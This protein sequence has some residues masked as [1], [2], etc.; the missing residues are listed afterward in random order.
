MHKLIVHCVGF[1]AVKGTIV[2]T[3]NWKSFLE[4][5]CF[6]KWLFIFPEAPSSRAF[7]LTIGFWI[8]PFTILSLFL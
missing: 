7:M 1:M 3:K 8:F 4:R 2:F 5:G 6:W